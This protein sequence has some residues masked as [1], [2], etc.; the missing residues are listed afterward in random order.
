MLFSASRVGSRAFRWMAADS[1]YNTILNHGLGQVQQFF[2]L[3][4]GHVFV[5]A[6]R[7]V[8]FRVNRFV[9]AVQP[10]VPK[11][12]AINP[13]GG[14]RLGR[15]P[16]FRHPPCLPLMAGSFPIPSFVVVDHVCSYLIVAKSGAHASA[17]SACGVIPAS[18]STGGS[19]PAA[20]DWRRTVLVVLPPV[21]VEPFHLTPSCRAA[22][23]FGKLRWR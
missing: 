20:Y 3:R 13:S 23:D 4:S 7:I 10:C 12:T 15:G 8:R 1:G 17:L 16:Q 21:V 11:S 22:G 5:V 2:G 9:V 18:F 14:K 6:I 19:I